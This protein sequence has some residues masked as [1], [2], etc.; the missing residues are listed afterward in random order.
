MKDNI[1]AL[2]AGRPANRLPAVRAIDDQDLFV[3]MLEFDPRL[4]DWRQGRDE[5]RDNYYRAR[6][7]EQE[8]QN[9]LLCD[10]A[11]VGMFSVLGAVLAVGLIL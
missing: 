2:P 11:T 4:E 6:A 5:L 1:I 7:Q 8:D 10:V 9:Q 3:N